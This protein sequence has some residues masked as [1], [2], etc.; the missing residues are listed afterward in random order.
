MDVFRVL[1]SIFW[2]S[3]QEGVSG[4]SEFF[5]FSRQRQPD[6]HLLIVKAVLSKVGGKS[7]DNTE[8]NPP[9]LC[10]LSQHRS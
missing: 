1:V 5:S 8:Q 2:V 10:I 6:V 3:S 7:Q 4:L 9:H